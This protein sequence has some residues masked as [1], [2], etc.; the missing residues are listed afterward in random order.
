MENNSVTLK[1]SRRAT[2]ESSYDT[3]LI[4]LNNFRHTEGQP[5]LV[6]YYKEDGKTIDSILAIGK[7]SGVGRECYD[8]ISSNS[9]FVV[10]GVYDVLPD[11]S[12][13]VNGARYICTLDGKV[14][15]VYLVDGNLRKIDEDI[16]E[17]KIKDI[18]TGFLWY[19]V[20]GVL[21]REDEFLTPQ[22]V[23]DAINSRLESMFPPK[24]KITSGPEKV[25]KLG[26]VILGPKFEIQVLD[27]ENNPVSLEEVGLS[28]SSTLGPESI[29]SISGN[30]IT[31]YGEL[32]ESCT[33]T[34]TAT[35]GGHSVSSEYSI[36]FTNPVW[37]GTVSNPRASRI[38]IGNPSEV[39]WKGTGKL[40]LCVSLND[41][42]LAIAIPQEISNI[43]DIRD[44]NGFSYISDYLVQEDYTYLGKPYTLYLL[45]EPIVMPSFYQI[46]IRNE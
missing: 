17:K 39:L 40:E 25:I 5:V 32:R 46:I 13:L 1:I 16:P 15:L 43:Q 21:K 41:Q 36:V 14:S 19:W 31:L 29:K 42:S 18:S 20:D 3:A 33:Y 34:F 10:D 45:S 44:K 27:Y 6:R 30:T 8:I 7:V 11:V 28:V 22:E 38:V 9:E 12:S 24:I 4:N 2:I 23:T 26:E 35:Y 37:Y